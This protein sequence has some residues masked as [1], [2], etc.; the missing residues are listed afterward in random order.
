MQK[1]VAFLVSSVFALIL[2]CGGTPSPVSTGN[3][4]LGNPQPN[5][6]VLNSL[7][8]STAMVGASG[9]YLLA[10]GSN[11][12]PTS[13]IQW[14]GTDLP[15]HCVNVDMAPV[16]CDGAVALAATIPASD[17]AT[18]GNAKIT[19]F[20]PAASGVSGGTSIA[21]NF[22]IVAPGA[23]SN[24]VR[25]VSGIT[26]PKRAV[27]DQI[28][29]KLYVS[30]ASTDPAHP[31]TIA[32]VDP[33]SGSAVQFVSATTNPSL[34][35]LSSDSGYLWAGLDG[36]G[37][38]A[39]YALP[40]VTPDI[41]F[42]LPVDWLGNA[43][44]AVSLEAAPINSHAVA[45]VPASV[46][47]GGNGNG[48]YIYDD[49]TPRPVHAAGY[50]GKTLGT[51][52][53]WVQWGKDDT[54][55]YGS[56]GPLSTLSVNASGVSLVSSIAAYDEPGIGGQFDRSN[57]LL[58][59]G[60]GAWDP[61]QGTLAGAFNTG[62]GPGCTPDPSLG[63]YYCV[64]AVPIGGSDVYGFYLE[65]FDLK[66]YGRIG[67]VLLGYSAGT[68]E[69]SVITGAPI[70]IVR[71]GNSGLAVL[72]QGGLTPNGPG[73]LFLIDG[74][75]I[76]PSGTLDSTIGSA[77]FPLPSMTSMTPDSASAGAGT[78]Q[79]TINGSGFV[80]DS[81]ACW[82]CNGGQTRLLPTN[83]VSPTQVSVEIPLADVRTAQ[84]L[85]VSIY[86]ESTGLFSSNALTF[87]ILPSSTTTSVRP[88]NI[89][90]LSM[91]WDQNG[92]LLYIGTADTD[93]AF[94][95][96]VIALNP[97]TGTVQ[98]SA[99][100]AS[101]PVFLADSAQGSYLYVGS[102]GASVLT[103]LSLPS[104]TTLAITPVFDG[105]GSPFL[106][107][108]L[109]AAPQDPNLVAATLIGN[110]SPAAQGGIVLY[111]SGVPLPQSLPGWARG[112]AVP[113]LYDTLAWSGSDSSLGASPSSWDIADSANNGVLFTLEATG[114]GVTY[115]GQG[116]T[117]FNT[118]DG[119]MHSDFGTGL[120]YGDGGSVGDPSTGAVIG[121]YGASGLLVPDSSLNRVFVLGQTSAQTQSFSY[122]IQSFDQKAMTPVSSIALTNLS[123]VPVAMVRWGS[124]G[125]AVLTVGGMPDLPQNGSGMLYVI[126]DPVFVSGAK[127]NSAASSMELVAQRSKRL[128]MRDVLRL[129]RGVR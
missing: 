43:Q 30:I 16:G 45:I 100:V 19:L 37:T 21:L 60:S 55:I 29:R 80:P 119:Y 78:V 70:Q 95:N 14:N 114:S 125:L 13:M 68:S 122:T 73:G 129:S 124:D 79:V 66:T 91:A 46:Q 93:P 115:L 47:S 26:V 94:P 67:E 118:G 123:G 58:Y 10:Y 116:S 97:A 36:K 9:A 85:E 31:D 7:A 41:S 106:V 61:V 44:N 51:P 77:V 2:G 102:G 33:V 110:G 113:A 48:V 15:T 35:S 120:V 28:H 126:E 71:W 57:G 1:A 49:A 87:T 92:Q 90:G 111:E 25:Q 108:D 4:G 99:P 74:A 117:V 18:A 17:L 5:P 104:L 98:A 96:S 89:V 88:L 52:L 11:F 32:V 34:L 8:P 105:T 22:S 82:N 109:K 3:T 53:S 112:Q 56:S 6:P 103:Q 64:T 86:D 62:G 101:E 38:V 39:R 84:P 42:A 81:T 65:V 69:V 23:S 76:N 121:S 20:T 83:Y 12:L 40:S 127:A 27:W 107:G 63:R 54:T 75:S 72:T 24:F 128:T 50:N 59:N